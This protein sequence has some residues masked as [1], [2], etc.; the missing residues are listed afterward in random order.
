MAQG[1]HPSRVSPFIR[2]SRFFSEVPFDYHRE[3]G[4]RSHETPGAS[5]DFIE[6]DSAGK[7]HLW[8]LKTLHAYELT[9]GR[10]LGQLMFYDWMFRSSNRS[11]QEMRLDKSGADLESIDRPEDPDQP[12]QFESWNILVCGG[13]GHEIAAGV[14]PIMWEH[15]VLSDKYF[16]NFAPEVAT[17]HL[18]HDRSGDDEGLIIR[19]I[20]R[21][22]VLNPSEMEPNALLSFLRSDKNDFY[23]WRFESEKFHLAPTPEAPSEKMFGLA[24]EQPESSLW[25]LAGRE[26]LYTADTTPPPG[27]DVS[28][29]ESD[30]V[31]KI[32]LDWR[33]PV[34]SL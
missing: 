14:N 1:G 23:V 5:F 19:N 29:Y 31:S 6:L 4:M 33:G 9:S 32:R 25:T 15:T 34:W 17:Y 20:W 28:F 12:L 24:K 30:D 11:Y 3:K 13:Y 27:S 8:E 18:Y 2:G 10:V 26:H 21:L 16:G 7:L 22:S